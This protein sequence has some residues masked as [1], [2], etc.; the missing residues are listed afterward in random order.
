M[1]AVAV[2]AYQKANGRK[3]KKLPSIFKMQ[4]RKINFPPV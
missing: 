4:R 3:I 1:V 2:N